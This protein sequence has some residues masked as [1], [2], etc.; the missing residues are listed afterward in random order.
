[1][2]DMKVALETS[3]LP[4]LKAAPPTPLVLLLNTVVL[5]M[6]TLGAVATPPVSVAR[7]RLKLATPLP[8]N[9]TLLSA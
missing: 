5:K 9:V 8:C 1:V 7:F 6:A 2:F 3:R 4:L